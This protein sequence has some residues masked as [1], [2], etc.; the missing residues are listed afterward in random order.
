MQYKHQ[1]PER[2]FSLGHTVLGY[3]QVYFIFTPILL[4]KGYTLGQLA[5]KLR[6]LDNVKADRLKVL[7]LNQAYQ[8]QNLKQ[9]GFN[10]QQRSLANTSK[11]ASTN[12]IPKK[13]C[14]QHKSNISTEGNPVF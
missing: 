10:K 12:Q 6:F 13:S 3:M 1:L 9:R 4:Q 2:L 14:L 5:C 11:N 8:D 7:T